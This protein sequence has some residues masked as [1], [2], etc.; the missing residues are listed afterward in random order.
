MTTIDPNDFRRPF[1]GAGQIVI[2]SRRGTP[3]DVICAGLLE[4]IARHSEYPRVDRDEFM[5]ECDL[6]ECVSYYVDIKV[7]RG[8]IYK[9]KKK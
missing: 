5:E 1:K 3:P 9:R 2:V 4:D 8:R 6:S 7:R